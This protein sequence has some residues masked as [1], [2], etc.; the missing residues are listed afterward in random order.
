MS[1]KYQ[2]L[3]KLCQQCLERSMR[4]SIMFWVIKRFIFSP[5]TSCRWAC[6]R[7]CRRGSPHSRSGWTGHCRARPPGWSALAH[8]ADLESFSHFLT[9]KFC[10][11]DFGLKKLS[12]TALR[13]SEF[14]QYGVQVT[15]IIYF[16]QQSHYQPGMSGKDLI[17]TLCLRNSLTLLTQQYLWFCRVF[18]PLYINSI[19]C[20]CD[21]TLGKSKASTAWI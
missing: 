6:R 7:W 20:H 18:C 15:R 17:K 12:S 16:N 14:P 19:F 13:L 9:P 8:W 3:S 1:L 4:Y 5:S 2:L 11:I 21:C 10:F